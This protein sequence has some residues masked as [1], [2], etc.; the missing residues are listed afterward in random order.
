MPVD[1]FHLIIG[2][3]FFAV[4]ALVAAVRVSERTTGSRQHTADRW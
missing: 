2:L 1:L 4:W 3:L